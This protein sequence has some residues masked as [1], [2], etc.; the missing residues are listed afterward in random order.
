[1]AVP[2]TRRAAA[3]SIIHRRKIRSEREKNEVK[4]KKNRKASK[5][6]RCCSINGLRQRPT[7]N[8]GRV[9][10]HPAHV[11]CEPI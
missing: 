3:G 8:V 10:V 11:E 4:E 6:T 7:Q 2:T 9:Q 1:L 5:T